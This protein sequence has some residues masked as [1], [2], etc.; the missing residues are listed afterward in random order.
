MLYKIQVLYGNILAS[1]M[2]WLIW[3]ILNFNFKNKFRLM[4]YLLIYMKFDIF[5]L[6]AISIS[7]KSFKLCYYI[8]LSLEQLHIYW[9]QVW[10]SGKGGRWWQWRKAGRPWWCPCGGG[11]RRCCATLW[12]WNIYKL[13]TYFGINMFGN[14]FIFIIQYK[15]NTIL[16]QVFYFDFWKEQ[17]S[18]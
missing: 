2:P 4:I 6:I 5:N 12:L 11:L 17:L 3:L 1:F 18:I 8:W 15:L 10:W 13:K 7:W 9:D 14:G 16:L